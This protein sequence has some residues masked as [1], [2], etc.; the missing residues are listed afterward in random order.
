MAGLLALHKEQFLLAVRIMTLCELLG[1]L[2]ANNR[3]H[4]VQIK[5]LWVIRSEFTSN[6]SQMIVFGPL[7]VISEGWLDA[8]L[9]FR[10]LIHHRLWIISL[11]SFRSRFHLLY[12]LLQDL[13]C[14]LWWILRWPLC[15][16]LYCHLL[17]WL[18]RKVLLLDLMLCRKGWALGPELRWYNTF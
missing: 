16:Y 17:F 1:E 10:N 9:N 11:V 14:L 3:R 5:T 12:N 18:H 8:S 2:I 4:I 7:F 15:G 6:L 13:D